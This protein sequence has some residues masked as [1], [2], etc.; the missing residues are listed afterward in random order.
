VIALRK[1]LITF[2]KADYQ[3]R[4]VVHSALSRARNKLGSL[5]KK[6]GFAGATVEERPFRAA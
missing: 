6:L 1:K 3:V 4:I 5:L 2:L